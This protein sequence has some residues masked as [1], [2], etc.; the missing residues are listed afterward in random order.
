[1]KT[2]LRRRAS[3]PK[4]FGREVHELDFTQSRDLEQAETDLDLDRQ[5]I[6][7]SVHESSH[8]RSM[9]AVRIVRSI[10]ILIG[11]VMLG[12]CIVLLQRYNNLRDQC[13]ALNNDNKHTC[14]VERHAVGAL[15]FCIVPPIIGIISGI[16]GMVATL[17]PSIP[18]IV[19]VVMDNATG[20]FFMGGGCT[21]AAMVDDLSCAAYRRNTCELHYVAVGC[22]FL[23]VSLAY[24]MSV[25]HWWVQRKKR[26]Q[27]GPC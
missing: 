23:G 16:S 25:R 14:R 3:V 27:A 1:M 11:P 15:R 24:S 10:Q 4:D 26:R 13:M 6:R 18:P 7:D 5:H 2:N 9:T 20:G 8:Q 21:L 22:F 17:T 19:T 12:I